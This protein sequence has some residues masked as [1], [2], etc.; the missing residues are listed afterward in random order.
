MPADL[1]WPGILFGLVI[2]A[3]LYVVSQYN[4]LLFASSAEFMGEFGLREV[5]K[6]MV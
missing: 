3:S 6:L 4:F 2:L 1:S 5:S